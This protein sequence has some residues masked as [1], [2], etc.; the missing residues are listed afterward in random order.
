MEKTQFLLKRL[1]AYGPLSAESQAAITAVLRP[2][3]YPRNSYMIRAGQR[4]RTVAFVCSGLF[5]QYFTTD[6]GDVIIKRFFPEG[7]LCSSIAALISGKP[8]D[9]SIKALEDSSVLEYDFETFRSLTRT[10]PDMAAAY[11]GYLEQ[12]W[13][14]EKEPLEIS[15]RYETARTRYIDFLRQFP[16]LEPRL[17]Q[18]EIA[19]YLGVTPTQLS[20]IRAGLQ[21]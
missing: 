6:N 21:D 2:K 7:Y 19:S 5:S 15:L 4:P 9:F 10:Y 14:V 17:R 11:I 13:V 1:T 16:S 20:R 12:H 3:T 18:H 8:S